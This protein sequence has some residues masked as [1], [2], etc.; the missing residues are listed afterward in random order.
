MHSMRPKARLLRHMLLK[1]CHDALS[2]CAQPMTDS[3]VRV[4]ESSDGSA[5]MHQN[6]RVEA[7]SQLGLQLQVFASLCSA[8]ASVI[9]SL[10][11]AAEL[12]VHHMLQFS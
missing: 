12:L 11:I 10:L 5:T 8:A 4:H 9:M 3:A 1:D 6:A 7:T 2:E